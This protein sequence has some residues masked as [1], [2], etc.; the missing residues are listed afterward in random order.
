MGLE[1][2]APVCWVRCSLPTTLA[3]SSRRRKMWP[4]IHVAEVLWVEKMHPLP[5]TALLALSLTL[6]PSL[7]SA[8][9]GPLKRKVWWLLLY[10]ESDPEYFLWPP[11]PSLH[12][13]C[14]F[15]SWP[16]P[17][18]SH[19]VLFPHFPCC[20]LLLDNSSQA[21]TCFTLASYRASSYFPFSVRLLWPLV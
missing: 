8:D 20:S 12:S 15:F 17:F 13:C 2:E 5:R 10:S 6:D 3:C 1:F 14:P 11:G 19:S 7:H 16:P 9:S 4:C 18:A 21:F